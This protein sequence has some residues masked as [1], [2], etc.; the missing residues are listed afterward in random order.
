MN[1]IRALLLSVSVAAAGM[2]IP[3][4]VAPQLACAATADSAALVVDTGASVTRY[5]VEI[6]RGGTDG[7]G[8]IKL[9]AQQYGLTY[10][11][12]FGGAAV[13]ALNGVG[14][15]SSSDCFADMPNFW[16]YYI[17]NSSGGWSWSGTGAGSISVDP[18]DV[19]GWSWGAGKD[20]SSHPQPPATRYEDVCTVQPGSGGSDDEPKNGG[21]KVDRNDRDRNTVGDT[22]TIDTSGGTTD[23]PRDSRADTN[24]DAKDG[25]ARSSRSG[26][27]AGPDTDQATEGLPILNA[28][29]IAMA[30]GPT[31]P[32]SE[33][34][35]GGVVVL[36]LIVALIVA[37]A[38]VA[39]RP[40]GRHARR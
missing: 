30:A 5:C 8:L 20:G 3:A 38:F 29:P 25:E 18:G 4:A 28:S 12:G 11:L 16:G 34:P 23:R 22:T 36:A 27:F 35:I 1:K 17:G 37:G 24:A 21:T 31:T 39:K 15:T 14:V 2:I 40:H 33:P 9:A 19:Q 13:C 6:P 26:A 32:T 7:I 10:N